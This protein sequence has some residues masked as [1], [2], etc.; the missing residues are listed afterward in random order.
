MLAR[1]VVL[2]ILDRILSYQSTEPPAHNEEISTPRSAGHSYCRLHRF[3]FTDSLGVNP[4]QL[5]RIENMIL[6]QVQQLGGWWGACRSRSALT[7]CVKLF[8]HVE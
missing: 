7:S 3:Q 2:W 1:A 5:D 8:S 4:A 6:H